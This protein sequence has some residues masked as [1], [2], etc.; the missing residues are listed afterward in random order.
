MKGKRIIESIQREID[1]EHTE[2]KTKGKN[3]GIFK[4]QG[5]YCSDHHEHDAIV[6]TE[7]DS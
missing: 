7:E 5:C 4:D 6:I 1:K 2:V 3:Q